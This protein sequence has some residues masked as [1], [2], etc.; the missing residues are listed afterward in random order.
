[1]NNNLLTT[2]LA[3]A[4]YSNADTL[5]Q[6]I[7]AVPNPDVALEMLLNVYTPPRK[8]TYFKRNDSLIAQVTHMDPLRDIVRFTEYEAKTKQVWYTT[9][10]DKEIGIYQDS[11]PNGNYYD[12]SWVKT[13]GVTERLER[14]TSF[15]EFEDR[16]KEISE[17]EFDTIYDTWE[18]VSSEENVTL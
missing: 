5:A 13:N 15:K 11:R 1:M 4:G 7:T 17:Q 16:W 8:G 9:K 10:E 2:I 3:N 12:Y 14:S 6:I 18:G